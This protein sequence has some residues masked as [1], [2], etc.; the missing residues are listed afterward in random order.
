MKKFIKI[1]ISLVMILT[2]TACGEK[3]DNT[4]KGAKYTV[5]VETLDPN[6]YPE[7]YPLI[8]A[9]DF[10]ESFEDLKEASMN[11]EIN[12]YQGI[13]DIFGVDGAYYE[14]CDYEDGNSLYKYYGWYA[15]DGTSVLIT[16]KADGNDLEF[17]AWTGNGII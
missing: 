16:F 1:F 14:N 11:A 9:D 7:E 4:T 3:A 12:G 6:V 17:F 2:L 13:V 15:D 8:A 10:K 5:D